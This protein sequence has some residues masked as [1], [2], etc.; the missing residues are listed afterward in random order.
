MEAATLP[1]S[2]STVTQVCRYVHRYVDIIYIH[3]AQVAAATA[4]SSSGTALIVAAVCC[5]C[6]RRRRRDGDRCVD[7]CRYRVDIV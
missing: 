7:M 2:P 6:W 5:C 3:R 4:V 1:S